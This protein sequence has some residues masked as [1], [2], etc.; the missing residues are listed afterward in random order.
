MSGVILTALMGISINC[1]ELI[2]RPATDVSWQ[3]SICAELSKDYQNIRLVPLKNVIL[4]N[5]MTSNDELGVPQVASFQGGRLKITVNERTKS[6]SI[7]EV[8]YFF[9]VDAYKEIWILKKAMN[10]GS[11]LQEK[12]ISRMSI[13]VAPFVGIK[14]FIY[15][16][17]IGKKLKNSQKSKSILFTDSV[18]NP[19]I[20]TIGDALT[21]LIVGGN[22]SIEM[23]AIAL[24]S[25]SE[26]SE[27][28]KV[29]LVAT[30]A[31]FDATI[32]GNKNVQ[33]DI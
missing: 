33:I 6:N 26:N 2:D 1:N 31:T 17:P 3:K 27:K 21:A 30:G 11:I 22:L 18:E 23:P 29:R 7:N 14:D 25:G 13:N 16:A 10:S 15:E 12:D 5:A 19:D 28:I 24:E 9:H 8:D 32:T 20:I 4:S